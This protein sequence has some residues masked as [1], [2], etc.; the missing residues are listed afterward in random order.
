MDMGCDYSSASSD[1][2]EVSDGY[3]DYSSDATIR[4]L[5]NRVYPKEESSERGVRP[6]PRTPPAWED[7][8]YSYM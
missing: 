4:F 5:Y 2:E 7:Y 3:A 1:H 6:N 8:K